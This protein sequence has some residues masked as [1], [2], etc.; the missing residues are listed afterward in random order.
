L[1][2]EYLIYRR[3]CEAQ[4]Q[5]VLQVPDP[6]IADAYALEF[7]IL[8]GVA[9]RTPAFLSGFGAAEWA[10]NKIQVKVAESAFIDGELNGFERRLIAGIEL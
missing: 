4:V 6:K 8:A 10:M 7:S 1:K 5:D 3:N 9:N 2:N